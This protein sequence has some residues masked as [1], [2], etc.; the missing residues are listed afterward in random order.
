M[1]VTIDLGELAG[2]EGHMKLPYRAVISFPAEE[3]EFFR[4]SQGKKIHFTGKLLKFETFAREIY[5]AEGMIC[6]KEEK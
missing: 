2:K 1:K 5:L 4:I 6:T 3:K